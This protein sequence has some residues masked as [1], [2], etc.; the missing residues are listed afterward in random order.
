MRATAFFLIILVLL[1]SCINI[2][3]R[4][5][6]AV[7]ELP[8]RKN[9]YIRVKT[10]DGKKY[11][12]RWL[13]EKDGNVVSIRNTQRVLIDTTDVMSYWVNDSV[14]E[15]VPFRK[16]ATYS[17]PFEIHTED[18][19]YNF[20]K[21]ELSDQYLKGYEKLG[22]KLTYFTIPLNHVEE[23]RIRNNGASFGITVFTIVMALA[24]M[25]SFA[26]DITDM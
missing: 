11:K 10:V 7:N 18:R 14:P 1:Q 8:E 9:A 21:I 13:E 20:V 6:Y 5:S 26:V 17:G 16:A 2:Y 12:L 3:K 24:V 19:V 25:F 15:M 22:A 4:G 23:I